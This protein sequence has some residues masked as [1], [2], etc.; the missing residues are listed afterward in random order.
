MKVKSIDQVRANYS[1]G[2]N[3]APAKYAEAVKDT[4]GVISAGVAAEALWAAK[5]QEAITRKSRAA[6]LSKVT[7]AQWQLAASTKGA[8][9]IGPGMQAA[10]DKQANNVKPYLDVLSGLTLA[11]RTADPATNVTNRVI[12]IAVALHKKKLG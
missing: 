7:D 9:R 4:A 10:I 2:A 1:S 12:P 6:G 11:P 3:I 8:A 5:M